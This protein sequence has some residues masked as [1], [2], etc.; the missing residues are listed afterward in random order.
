VALILLHL[1]GST[2]IAITSGE[3]SYLGF[4]GAGGFTITLKSEN[5]SISYCHVSPDFF[6]S[7][8]ECISKGEEIGLVGPL[9]VYNVPN[10]PYKD[11]YGRPTN[12]GKYW[13]TFAFNNKKRRQSRQSFRLL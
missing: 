11:K 4:N 8:G 2:L 5:Y 6:V 1:L 3:I 10:N 13:S 12:R 9:N 7:V